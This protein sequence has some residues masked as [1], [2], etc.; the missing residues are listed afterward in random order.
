MFRK[1]RRNKDVPIMYMTHLMQQGKRET[2]NDIMKRTL[3]SLEQ[4]YRM[5]LLFNFNFCYNCL[6]KKN[7]VEFYSDLEII[8]KYG[9]LEYKYGD[10]EQG[11]IVFENALSNYPKRSDIW[12]I[13]ID[14]LIKV[15]KLDE[16]RYRTEL[17]RVKYQVYK[18]NLNLNCHHLVVLSLVIQF[19]YKELQY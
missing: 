1:Y 11:R 10:P 6:V 17:L 14:M 4:K 13:Y 19:S 15:H 5:F 12:S 7:N 9:Q 18:H 8:S 3:Q 16:A 2:A